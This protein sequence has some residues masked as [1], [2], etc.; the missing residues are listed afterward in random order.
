M[1]SDSSQ[2]L[3]ILH[4]ISGLGDGGAESSLVTL[5]RATAKDCEHIV[6]SLT[7][8][9]KHSYQLQE[10]GAHVESLS[11]NV[12]LMVP[13]ELWRLLLLIRRSRPSVIQGWMYHG[14]FF[15]SLIGRLVSRARIIWGIHNTRLPLDGSRWS[16]RVINRL[17]AMMSRR[18]CDR[19]VYCSA[20]AATF[21]ETVGYDPNKTRVI[22]N[23]VDLSL[24]R[25]DAEARLE[26]RAELG[27]SSE[28]IVIGMVAR[29]DPQ[30]DHATALSAFA[31][32]QRS[33]PAVEFLLVGTGIVSSNPRLSSL[34]EMHG[35]LKRLRLLGSR[36]DIPRIMNAVDLHVLSSSN[37]AA[38]NVLLEA[39][40]C[41]TP[42][43]ATDV[44]DARDM[45]GGTGW[46]A[47]VRDPQGLAT[48]ICAA[49]DELR[50]SASDWASRQ[51]LAR[52]H[53]SGNYS[54]TKSARN[55][56]RV[57]SSDC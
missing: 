48:V 8:E 27:V 51:K 5:C 12:P 53:A 57:W 28:A 34:L 50:S 19:I 22:P 26:I 7:G 32:V 18:W 15:A 49:L 13:L 46:I 6:V 47:G 2:A 14:N 29:W 11:L 21:H 4:V 44:G 37:E 38:P 55:Y 56:L 9:G 36:S 17:C 52:S 1:A 16:T 30:K 45:V 20:S 24:F 23:G 3:R 43:I 35:G 41:G 40:A 31:L 42:C 10:A 33:V 39:M 25:P 54:K